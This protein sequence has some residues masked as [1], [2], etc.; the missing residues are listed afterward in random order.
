M[1]KNRLH[2]LQDITKPLE[3][4]ELVKLLGCDRSCL[5]RWEQ[6]GEAP[7]LVKFISMQDVKDFIKADKVIFA[8]VKAQPE[9]SKW[10]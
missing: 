5:W 6:K 4:G 7:F 10:I 2:H 9:F 1:K 3:I 8:R